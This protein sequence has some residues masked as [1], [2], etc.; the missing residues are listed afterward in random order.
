[1]LLE[2]PTE[3]FTKS[4]LEEWS[5]ENWGWA[6]E[7][8]HR[9]IEHQPESAWILIDKLIEAAEDDEE[10]GCIAAGPLEDLLARYGPQFVERVEQAAASNE[11]FKKCLAG[12]WGHLRFDAS[13]YDRVQKSLGR[14][15]IR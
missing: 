12:V 4:W 10:L 15:K 14:H 13:V 8:L 9:L 7:L 2:F 6:T 11:R 1:M 3:V 5:E